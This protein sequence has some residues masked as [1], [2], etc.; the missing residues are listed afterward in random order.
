[1][2][3]YKFLGIC[4]LFGFVASIILLSGLY[5]DQRAKKSINSK[6]F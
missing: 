3:E 2:E 1:M 6:W 5:I 4:F